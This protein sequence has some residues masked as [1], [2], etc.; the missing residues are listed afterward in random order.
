MFRTWKTPP[1]LKPFAVTTCGLLA[2]LFFNACVDFSAHCLRLSTNRIDAAALISVPR[3]Q[4]LCVRS[5][6]AVRTFRGPKNEKE[7]QNTYSELKMLYVVCDVCWLAAVNH[8]QAGEHA[9]HLSSASLFIPFRMIKGTFTTFQCFNSSGPGI[10][11]RQCT[12]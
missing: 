2:C 4:L 7:T 12:V 6:R 8:P 3:R 9:T 1:K 5:S 10:K 11:R